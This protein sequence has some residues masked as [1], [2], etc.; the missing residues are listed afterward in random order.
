MRMHL[1][2]H[3]GILDATHRISRLFHVPSSI[4]IIIIQLDRDALPLLLFHF[5]YFF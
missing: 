3:A 4:N 1:P 5:F 2:L